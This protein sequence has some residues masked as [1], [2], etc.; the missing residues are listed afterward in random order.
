[1]HGNRGDESVPLARHRLHESRILRRIPQRPAHLQDAEIQAAL[2][3]DERISAPQVCAQLFSQDDVAGA[4]EQQRQHS[5]RLRRELYDVPV[6]AQL[7]CSSV[8]L[9][10]AEPALG[11]RQ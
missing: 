10:Q 5:R 6:T 3:V 7:A 9:E 11:G 8:E 1:M 2:E 4:G